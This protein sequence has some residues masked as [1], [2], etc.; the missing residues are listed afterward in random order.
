MKKTIT[1]FLAMVITMGGALAQGIS[2][3]DK[4]KAL[5]YLKESQKEL[6]NTV[7]GLSE[8][9]LTYKPSPESWSVAECMEHIAVA[10]SGI[11]MLVETALKEKPNPERRA[12]VKLSDDMIIRIVTGR[13]Q[14]VK[15]QKENEPTNRFGSYTG[16]VAEFKTQR[17]NNMKFI[18]TTEKDLRNYYANFP[19]GLADA[20]QAVLLMSAHTVRH[21]KQIKEILDGEAYP[22]S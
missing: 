3:E 1:L 15:T 19:F 17:K 7:K 6:M 16:S 22:S 2:K 8:E 9:Q 21:T 10:E 5:A 14:K 12:E 18:K 11:F 20:Y 4:K 13:E